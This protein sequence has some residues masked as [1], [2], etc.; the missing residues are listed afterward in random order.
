MAA[1]ARVPD[2]VSELL[3]AGAKVNEQNSDGHTALM[4][5]Y[6][7]G[8]TKSRRSGNDTVSY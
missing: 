4:F 8:R 5:A 7:A 6:N 3:K 2:V 1:A